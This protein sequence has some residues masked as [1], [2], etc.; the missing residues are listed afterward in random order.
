MRNERKTEVNMTRKT[1]KLMR[2]VKIAMVAALALWGVWE[3]LSLDSRLVEAD[4]GYTV[5]EAT[6][7][8]VVEVDGDSYIP[9][10]HTGVAKINGNGEIVG[11]K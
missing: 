11:W 6:I 10:V 1:R 8:T 2:K 5:R 3:A 9:E 4:L 7:Y